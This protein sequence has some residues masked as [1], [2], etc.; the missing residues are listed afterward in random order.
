MRSNPNRRVIAPRTA[1]R[2]IVAL[3]PKTDRVTPA[4]RRA[5]RPAR[6]TTLAAGLVLLALAAS[7]AATAAPTVTA[8]ANRRAAGNDAAAL[9]KT[10]LLPPGATRSPTEPAGD[11]QLLAHP[12]LAPVTPNLVDRHSWWVVPAGLSTV[13]SYIEA[14]RPAGSRLTVTSGGVTGPTTPPNAFEGFD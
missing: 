1:E 2:W 7:S 14:H 13:I 12:P 6:I 4:S 11:A 8:A 5:T 3:R 10:V 9:L